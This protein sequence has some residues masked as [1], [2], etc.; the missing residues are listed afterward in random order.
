MTKLINE[1]DPDL[2]VFDPSYTNNDDPHYPEG[3]SFVQDTCEQQLMNGKV[4]LILDDNYT[5]RWEAPEWQEMMYLEKLA[6]R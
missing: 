1:T 4:I 3:F 5:R 2:I 6:D